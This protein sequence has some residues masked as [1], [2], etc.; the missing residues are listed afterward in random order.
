ML[1]VGVAVD[2]VG[3]GLALLGSGVSHDA[4]RAVFITV[5][6][7]LDKVSLGQLEALGLASSGF[8]H[9]SALLTVTLGTTHDRLWRRVVGHALT[10]LVGATGHLCAADAISPA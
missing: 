7:M 9:R 1:A 5:R 10:L 8:F 4:G 6:R 3:R 2:R